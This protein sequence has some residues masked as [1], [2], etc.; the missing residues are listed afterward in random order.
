M[1]N[2][3]RGDLRISGAGSTGGGIFNDV[4]ISGAGKVN[5]SIECNFMDT[6]GASEIKGDIKAKILKINGASQIDG[7]L[8]SEDIVINGGCTINGSVETRKIRIH[9]G[10]EIGGSLHTGSVEIKGSVRIKGDCE[11]ETFKN[12]GGF[13]IQGL[14]NADSIYVNIGGK[15]T[16]KE[17]GG[18]KIEVRRSGNAVLVLQK[19][20]KDIL[21]IK[22]NLIS[23]VIEGD[24][25]YLEST[26]AKVVRGNNISIGPD[27]TIGLIEYKDTLNISQGSIVNEQR[28]L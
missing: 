21:N 28:K 3:S 5:G 10:S 17:I 15:C 2:E 6:S 11:A 23:D 26:I 7:N 22:E 9:G 24:D 1:E 14:L 4:R 16:V 27:C 12:I 8:T 20:L 25:I 19:M 13:N 18:G